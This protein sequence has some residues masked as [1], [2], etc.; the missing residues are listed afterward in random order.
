MNKT[1]TI[2]AAIFVL[3]LVGVGGY[4]FYNQSSDTTLS[5]LTSNL[6]ESSPDVETLDADRDE[7]LQRLS[8]LKSI[9]I[10]TKFLD[11][12]AFNSLKD[13][14]ITIEPQSVG[15]S[16]PFEPAGVVDPA[17][18]SESSVGI[19]STRNDTGQ[20]Q[21]QFGGTTTLDQLPTENN[22]TENSTNAPGSSTSTSESSAST[23]E[24][25][26]Q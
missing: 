7:T 21:N 1:Y 17:D 24:N 16:N 3:A 13:F 4:F 22:A 19:E 11:S 12:Q 20:Q 10:N 23:A 26:Q 8:N 25:G 18:V 2:I 14:G 15:R 9:E 5:G 6:T